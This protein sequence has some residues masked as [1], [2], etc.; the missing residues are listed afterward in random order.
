MNRAV[1][2][3]RRF[4]TLGGA[5]AL[6]AG[7]AASSTPLFNE[8]AASVGQVRGTPTTP[9]FGLVQSALWAVDPQH[10]C[11]DL[12]RN[13]ER[14]VETIESTG[15]HCNWLAFHDRVLTGGTP[16]RALLNG[17]LT[18]QR[19]T[20][21]VDVIATAARSADC[22]VSFGAPFGGA[23]DHTNH[24]GECGIAIS[25]QGERLAGPFIRSPFGLIVLNT[26][27]P[28]ATLLA[29]ARSRGALA[30]ISMIAGPQY[31][32]R[33][34]SGAQSGP[35]AGLA[36]LRVAAAHADLQIDCP[37]RWLGDTAAFDNTGAL[38]GHCIDADERTLRVALTPNTAR[39]T[40]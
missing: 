30:V 15:P 33:Q 23:V 18:D 14:M 25:P 1:I 27:E 26:G 6:L 12:Q 32:T 3:R 17:M 40:I 13:V 9:V 5:C 24:D 2:S 4:V 29:D 20:S 38:L 22:W 37:S 7:G 31:A 16:P 10:A 39:G 35:G 8:D 19:T 34:V 36:Q 28:S 21:L 11:L